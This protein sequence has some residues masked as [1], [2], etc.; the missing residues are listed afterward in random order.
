[1]ITV[2]RLTNDNEYEVVGRADGDSVD[3]E[4]LSYYPEEVWQE[5]DPAWFTERMDGPRVMAT[6]DD[7]SVK[8]PEEKRKASFHWVPYKGPE[9]GE[10]W[11][12]ILTGEVRYQDQQ[13]TGNEDYD[14]GR[15]V[16]EP[17]NTEEMVEYQGID[18]DSFIQDY[19]PVTAKFTD[20]EGEEHYGE[21]YSVPSGGFGEYVIAAANGKLYATEEIE[22]FI[23]P[24]PQWNPEEIEEHEMWQ[25]QF[26]RVKNNLGDEVIPPMHT[27]NMGD[28]GRPPENSEMNHIGDGKISGKHLKFLKERIRTGDLGPISVD[29]TATGDNVDYGP[30]DTDITDYHNGGQFAHVD[31]EMPIEDFL[32]TQ[33]TM[34]STDRDHPK[35]VH[36]SFY[37]SARPD[38]VKEYAEVLEN[39]PGE[40]PMPFIEL[41][42]YGNMRK[43]QEGRH[44]ALAALYAGHETMPVRLVINAERKSKENFV[45]WSQDGESKSKVNVENRLTDKEWVPYVGPRGGEGW[46]NTTTENVR[47]VDEK[48][49]VAEND[50]ESLTEEDVDQ[51]EIHQSWGQIETTAN[52]VQRGDPLMYYDGENTWETRVQEVTDTGIRVVDAETRRPFTIETNEFGEPAN[53]EA[54]IRKPQAVFFGDGVAAS[55]SSWLPESGDITDVQLDAEALRSAAS[56]DGLG[57][58][59]YLEAFAAEASERGVD[60]DRIIDALETGLAKHPILRTEQADEI[61]ENGQRL[62]QISEELLEEKAMEKEWVPYKGPYGGEGWQNTLTGEIRYQESKPTGAGSGDSDISMPAN[63][64]LDSVSAAIT[65]VLGAAVLSS[66][67]SQLQGGQGGTIDPQML[68]TAG[69]MYIAQTGKGSLG[70]L[71]EALN[72]ESEDNPKDSQD[73]TVSAGDHEAEIT[74]Q[75]KPSDITGA[76]TEVTDNQTLTRLSTQLD[77]DQK[78]S[79][80]AWTEAFLSR[81]DNET[82]EQF[83]DVVDQRIRERTITTDK[84]RGGVV[85]PND[86]SIDEAKQAMQQTFDQGTYQSLES[87]IEADTSVDENEPDPWVLAALTQIGDNDELRSEYQSHFDVSITEEE[88][89]ESVILSGGGESIEMPTGTTDEEV[90]SAI[91]ETIGEDFLKH[92]A[93]FMEDQGMDIEDPKNWIKTSLSL[94][95]IDNPEGFEQTVTELQDSVITA[96]EEDAEEDQNRSVEL[97]SDFDPEGDWQSFV[98]PV[99]DLMEEGESASDILSALENEAKIG[100]HKL[101]D[102]QIRQIAFD[103]HKEASERNAPIEA[104]ADNPTLAMDWGNEFPEAMR[105]QM[106]ERFGDEYEQMKESFSAWSDNPHDESMA[107]FWNYVMNESGNGNIPEG[108]QGDPSQDGVDS[109]ERMHEINRDTLQEIYGESIPVFRPVTGKAAKRLK[110]AKESDEEEF[111]FSHRPAETWSSDIEQIAQRTEWEDEDMTVIRRE[112][113]PEQ[114]LASSMIGSPGMDTE[115]NEFVV[116]SDSHTEYK[117]DDV[118]VEDDLKDPKAVMEQVSWANETAGGNEEP[119]AESE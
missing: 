12:H 115:D 74:T 97:I 81:V 32:A 17:E 43:Y 76:I 13:P 41:G 113:S 10:G 1:M 62:R 59:S 102:A 6:S 28:G 45:D 51:A 9:G 111:E 57:D 60:R 16:S 108:I 15:D 7:L 83:Q 26:K 91:E 104:T 18:D 98:D 23:E 54:T 80:E 2:Y 19:L 110:E 56:T 103:A 42:A 70:E 50:P 4:L 61:Y 107:S 105:D 109:I 68:V 39:E 92:T 11:Q 49:E 20:K 53:D 48:P 44:R 112:V 119:E 73:V 93:G 31:V 52:D 40:M 69:A 25:S 90:R 14:H 38:D 3:D 101:E 86:L 30:W 66:L 87:L 77:D 22:S 29:F 96:V 75:T 82:V 34:L 84:Y 95:H 21:I 89:V 106:E 85:V 118:L 46:R 33:A 67:K 24:D 71:Q 47:Y 99:S 100:E 65:S 63:S 78:E 72:E 79:A 5:K 58:T 117:G 27:R 55:E 94:S 64:T 36:R 8:D 35:E 37:G 116:M 114:V 88:E